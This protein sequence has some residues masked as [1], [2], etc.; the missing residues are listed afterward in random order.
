MF[1]FAW[2]WVFILIPLPYLIRKILPAAEQDTTAL[3]ITFINEL[4]T[5]NEQVTSSYT[6]AWYKQLALLAIWILLVIATARP[7]WVGDVFPAEPTGRDMLLAVDTSGSMQEDDM[8]WNNRPVD[9]LFLIQKL[10][11]PFIEKRE[12]DRIGLLLFGTNAYL[13][14]PLTFDRKTVKTWLD[15]SF[16][17][18][19]G[20]QTAIGDAI[21]LGVKR[22]YSENEKSRVL[23]LITDGSNN[24]GEMKPEDATNIAVKAKVKIYTVGIGSDK[25]IRYGYSSY[26]ASA[27]LDEPAL[28][29]I[30]KQTGGKYFRARNQADLQAISDEINKLEPVNQEQDQI[31]Q[32][33]EYYIWPLSLAVLLALCV[34]VRNLYPQLTYRRPL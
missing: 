1:E 5:I 24:A 23:V 25:M 4:R 6:G 26:R 2:P 13:H 30:A 3:N 9:R 19:A 7:Q 16:I 17:G 22:L 32:I 15:E 28:K 34:L 11:G 10:F 33:E 14:A 29:K 20:T 31:R 27:D 21:A 12:G 18:I 8:S